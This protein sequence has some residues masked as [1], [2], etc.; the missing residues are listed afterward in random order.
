MVEGCDVAIG[1]HFAVFS[2]ERDIAPE[3]AFGVHIARAALEETDADRGL[4]RQ[5]RA[6]VLAGDLG[7]IAKH[8]GAL[9]MI[10][11]AGVTGEMG[12][13]GDGLTFSVFEHH[14]GG[15]LIDV[16]FEIDTH[17]VAIFFA[18]EVGAAIGAAAFA[19]VGE[20]VL[21][22]D[23][24]PDRDGLQ[25]IGQLFGGGGELIEEILAGGHELRCGN[26]AGVHGESHGGL[27]V[28]ADE[29]EIGVVV[30]DH[31]QHV[32]ER[33]V[34]RIGGGTADEWAD[35]RAF[36]G[37]H[38]GRDQTHPGVARFEQ[39][40]GGGQRASHLANEGS[41]FA[42]GGSTGGGGDS[43]L[44]CRDF[45]TRLSDL[46]KRWR[47]ETDQGE[48][49]KTAETVHD[50]KDT[51]RRGLVLAFEGILSRRRW[52]E[53]SRMGG[54]GLFVGEDAHQYWGRCE[55]GGWHGLCLEVG[56]NW[57][58][59]GRRVLEYLSY[60]QSAFDGRCVEWLFQ[61][62]RSGMGKGCGVRVCFGFASG[63]RRVILGCEWG[64]TGFGWSGE[65]EFGLAELE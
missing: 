39:G 19:I 12:D 17:Q 55:P 62:I 51:E 23:R 30:R 48:E 11:G 40:D 52:V 41:Y 44:K 63:W 54:G 35:V 47:R 14:D 15:L 26:L 34:Q 13:G 27:D 16:A 2:G 28:I 43:K 21:S 37:V 6:E 24:P 7:P 5:M 20:A 18:H 59:M 58:A 57:L 3:H 50:G 38:V 9:R 33:Q 46:R 45:E 31:E 1:Q 32:R 25:K 56:V 65:L 64:G 61:A 8:D 10:A 53:S 60:D 36:G 42:S 29:V 22:A 4:R 49:D